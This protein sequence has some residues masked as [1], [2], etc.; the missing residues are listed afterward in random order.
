MT[1]SSNYEKKKLLR[2]PLNC[3]SIREVNIILISI[4]IPKNVPKNHKL[5]IN[6]IYFLHYRKLSSIIIIY[7]LCL[8]NHIDQEFKM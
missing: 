6:N 7:Y 4:K 1:K 2:V 5:F 3:N 8:M